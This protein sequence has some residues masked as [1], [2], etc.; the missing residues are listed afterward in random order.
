MLK[1]M[2]VVTGGVGSGY[3]HGPQCRSGMEMASFKKWKPFNGCIVFLL[4]FFSFFLSTVDFSRTS[5]NS[6]EH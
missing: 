2:V 6:Q 3:T 1:R 5:T 4:F